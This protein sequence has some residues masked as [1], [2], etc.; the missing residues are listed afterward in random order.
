MHKDESACRG[1]HPDWSRFSG[2][3][4][5]LPTRYMQGDPSLRLNPGFV[6]DDPRC[7]CALLAGCT[8]CFARG[9]GILD[10]DNK[11]GRPQAAF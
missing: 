6:Q 10:S 1:R 5:D 2:G 11:K 4:R 7:R 8:L 3:G 9:H